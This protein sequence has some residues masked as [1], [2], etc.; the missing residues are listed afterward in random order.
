MTGLADYRI[1]QSV[2]WN[3]DWCIDG[4]IDC[5]INWNIDLVVPKM[6]KRALNGVL[7]G[8]SILSCLHSAGN[9]PVNTSL[10]NVCSAKE[11]FVNLVNPCTQD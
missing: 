4:I 1:C 5:S 3:I 7:V 10:Y 2:D 8:M 6:L 11:L 9:T